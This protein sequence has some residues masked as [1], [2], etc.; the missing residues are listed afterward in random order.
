MD[1]T[2]KTFI[3][4]AMERT[5]RFPYFKYKMVIALEGSQL[6]LGNPILK[7]K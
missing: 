5:K 3:R 7:K 2:V 1:G 4:I 6:L